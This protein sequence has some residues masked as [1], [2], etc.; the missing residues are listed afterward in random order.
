MNINFARADE[1]FIKS[2]VEQGYYSNATELVRD[3]VRKMREEEERKARFLAAIKIGEQQLK[4]GKTI[5]YSD[6]FM[7]EIEK[8]AVENATQGK[9]INNP[10]V[11]P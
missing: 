1:N 11:L 3:A 10:D 2:K 7:D 9:P 6:D 4:E 8:N 5:P